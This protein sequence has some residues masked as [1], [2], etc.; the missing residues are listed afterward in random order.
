ML[1]IIIIRFLGQVCDHT[2]RNLHLTQ[3]EHGTDTLGAMNT[4]THTHSHTHIRSSEHTQAPE[5]WA[6]RSPQ[7]TVVG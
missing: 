4:Y 2:Q 3:R 5:Q 7:G 1:Q 6:A